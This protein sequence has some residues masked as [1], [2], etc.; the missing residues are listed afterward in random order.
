MS[1]N[2][3]AGKI[4]KI[5]Y[6][7]GGGL[8]CQYDCCG[9]PALQRSEESLRTTGAANIAVAAGKD[10]AFYNKKSAR[11][12]AESQGGLIK[13]KMRFPG[14]QQHGLPSSDLTSAVDA[15]AKFSTA[16]PEKSL[17]FSMPAQESSADRAP[18][19]AMRAFRPAE[20]VRGRRGGPPAAPRPGRRG[21]APPAAGGR[22]T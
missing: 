2:S 17:K 7:E 18:V 19:P 10:S 4:E 14:R 6:C 8:R 21:G 11:C 20:G 16:S 5:N 22:A 9:Q 1:R 12:S 13:R 15:Q 3:E